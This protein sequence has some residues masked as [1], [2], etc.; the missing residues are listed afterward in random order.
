MIFLRLSSLP[1]ALFLYCDSVLLCAFST[2]F[3]QP[4]DLFLLATEVSLKG[5]FRTSFTP[6]SASFLSTCLHR[7]DAST[8]NK[9]LSFPIAI[10]VFIDFS[11]I[12]SMEFAILYFSVPRKPPSLPSVHTSSV[13][14]FVSSFWLIEPPRVYVSPL[15]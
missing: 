7:E 10:S 2:T 8:R 3:S 9:R 13:P 11:F 14:S 15:R 5:Q 6:R 1:C 4:S 12:T